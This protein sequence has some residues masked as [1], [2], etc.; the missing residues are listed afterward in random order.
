VVTAEPKFGAEFLD[1][2]VAVDQ[3][4]ANEAGK[5]PKYPSK[6]PQDSK[7]L[8]KYAYFYGKILLFELGHCQNQVCS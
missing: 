2:F 7:N 1:I 6:Q 4:P 5:L 8:L 3:S